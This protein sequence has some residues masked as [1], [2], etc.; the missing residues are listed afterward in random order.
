MD[1]ILFRP[2]NDTSTTHICSKYKIGWL[3]VETSARGIHSFRSTGETLYSLMGKCPAKSTG[4]AVI[5]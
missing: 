5:G 4:L 3:E 1:M 2:E